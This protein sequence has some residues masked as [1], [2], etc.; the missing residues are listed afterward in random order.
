MK[1]WEIDMEMNGFEVLTAATMK[2]SC[3]DCNDDHSEED[4]CLLV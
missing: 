4:G 2:S 1:S 3:L